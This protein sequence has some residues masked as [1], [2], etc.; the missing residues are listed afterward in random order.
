MDQELRE[1]LDGMMAQ[2]NGQH[3][4]ILGRLGTLETE[5]T[6]LRVDMID[7]RTVLMERMDRL[8]ARVAKLERPDE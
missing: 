4:V 1:Y 6:R 8:Q 5:Q 2:I 7:T 3:G